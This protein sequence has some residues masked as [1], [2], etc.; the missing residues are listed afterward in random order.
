MGLVLALKAFIKAFKDPIQAEEF[1]SG[2]RIEIKSHESAGQPSHLRLLH[3]LQ[4]SSRLIDFLKEDISSFEDEQVGAAVRKIHEDSAKCLE[5]LV[6]IR[7]VMEQ[8]EGEKINVPQ[9]Y[10]PL[11][12][13]VVGNVKG[14]PPFV[15]V[16]VH[17]GW[18]A[19]KRSLPKKVGDQLTDVICPAE[20]EIR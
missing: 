11:K 18:K 17:K 16:L 8:N 2:K 9:G 10:D 1:V 19:H 3:L 15:G 7:P 6:T 13:K 14:E 12:I 5:D 4:Q 20:V